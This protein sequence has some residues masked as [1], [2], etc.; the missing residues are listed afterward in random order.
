[1][2][3]LEGNL[4]GQRQDLPKQPPGS[5]K[6]MQLLKHVVNITDLLGAAMKLFC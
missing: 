5:G 4:G 1:M 6:K 2:H 3:R